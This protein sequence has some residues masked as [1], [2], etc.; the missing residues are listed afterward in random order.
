MEQNIHRR[1]EQKTKAH[2]NARA[3]PPHIEHTH[4]TDMIHP[5]DTLTVTKPHRPM[6]TSGEYFGNYELQLVSWR[7]VGCIYLVALI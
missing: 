5:L 2:V 1:T 3:H 4:T 6:V 7:A